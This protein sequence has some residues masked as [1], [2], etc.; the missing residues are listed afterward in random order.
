MAQIA[1]QQ[2]NSSNKMLDSQKYQKYYSKRKLV[3][4]YEKEQMQEQKRNRLAS[5]VEDANKNYKMGAATAPDESGAR[6][7]P[8]IVAPTSI[9][10][11]PEFED[12]GNDSGTDGGNYSAVSALTPPGSEQFNKIRHSIL[13]PNVVLHQPNEDNHLAA[14]TKSLGGNQPMAA[15]S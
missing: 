8:G 2:I 13:E 3:A 7:S 4:Q 9:K 15:T 1:L 12:E 14:A 5:L 11:E 10:A 6:D